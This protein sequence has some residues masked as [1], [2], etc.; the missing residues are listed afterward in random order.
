MGC[1]CVRYV[2]VRMP[3]TPVTSGVIVVYFSFLIFS[4]F[5][6]FFFPFFLFLSLLSYYIYLLCTC[7]LY[8]LTDKLY[9]TYLLKVVL[10]FASRY[11]D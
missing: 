7:I 2:R 5:L 4:F 3:A 10:K 9:F 6:F 8:L 1:W 11:H